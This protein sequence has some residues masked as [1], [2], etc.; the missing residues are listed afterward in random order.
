MKPFFLLLF[1]FFTATVGSANTL[2][3]ARSDTGDIPESIKST[4]KK[5]NGYKLRTGK[6]NEISKDSTEVYVIDKTSRELVLV[7]LVRKVDRKYA[8]TIMHFYVDGKLLRADVFRRRKGEFGWKNAGKAFYVFEDNIL[9]YKKELKMEQPVFPEWL[10][11]H[12]K[13]YYE[14]G[15][16]SLAN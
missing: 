1:F 8:E 14:K 9:L 4:L 3:F 10:L 11:A 2:A 6:L 5:W 13:L 7:H 15:I 16:V 12:A